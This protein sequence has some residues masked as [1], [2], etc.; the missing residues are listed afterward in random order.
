MLIDFRELFPKY[1]LRFN[2]VLHVGAN[3]GEEFGV[4]NELGI[5]KQIWI[6]ANPELI[7]KLEDNVMR[8]DNVMGA[9]NKYVFNICAGEINQTTVLHV[10]N[11]A[12]QSSSVLELGTHK[13]V[14][15]DVHYT[16]DV[17]V[18]MRRLDT[19]F[20]QMP[21]VIEGVDLLVMD[22][23]GAELM[24]LRGL[25]NYVRQFKAIYTEV[26]NREVY[27]KGALIED[28]DLFMTVHGFRR[29]E[30]FNNGGFFDRLGWSDALYIK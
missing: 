16:H 25:G 8:E 24:A 15:P 20:D 11:N 30:T 2:G 7:R 13:E 22:I 19:M 21:T 26:N 6:E 18:L 17:E 28:M 29:V 23:Q 3:V 9:S 10:A 4:Y 14:H 27:K 12:G 5:H 1:G